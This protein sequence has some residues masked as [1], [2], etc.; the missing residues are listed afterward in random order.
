MVISD[1][2]SNGTDWQACTGATLSETLDSIDATPLLFRLR[3]YCLTGRPGHSLRALRRAYAAS[4]LLNLPH[5]NALIRQIKA[6]PALRRLCGFG[7]VLPHRT[8]FN[9]FIR[10][11]S[12]HADL[13]EAALAGLT[14][15]LK[16]LLPDLG[17]TVAVAATSWHLTC[18][19]SGTPEVPRR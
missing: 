14:D 19:K 5:T 11:L 13:V 16:A 2:I 1:S 4:F 3:L 7:D 18:P 9:R 15:R 17:E 12:R 10:R 6:D 8:T